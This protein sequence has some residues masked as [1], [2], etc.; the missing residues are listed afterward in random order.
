MFLT[1]LILPAM[2]YM[3]KLG[4]ADF[5]KLAPCAYVEAVQLG[6]VPLDPV[7][8]ADAKARLLLARSWD[9]SNPVVPEFLGQIALMRFHMTDFSPRVQMVF[10]REAASE[11]D[12]AIVLRPNSSYLWAARMTTGNFLIVTDE[13]VGRDPALKARETS[14][15]KLAMRH[16]ADLGP[17]EKPVLSQIVK[18]GTLRYG[19]LSS[20]ERLLVDRAVERAKVLGLKI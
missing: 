19:E 6:K 9:A 1:L 11:F 15:L 10:L 5:L 3:A 20:I 7:L 16:A 12:K 13:Q 17:W 4:V 2:I 8:L 18:V 14:Q